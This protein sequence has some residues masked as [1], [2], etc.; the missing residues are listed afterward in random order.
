MWSLALA[1]AG[2]CCHPLQQTLLR[3]AE[4]L[5]V[6]AGAGLMGIVAAHFC[7]QLTLTD[8]DSH[9]LDN[10]RLSVALNT[11]LA[12]RL[13]VEKLE[14]GKHPQAW[15]SKFDVILGVE[16]LFTGM[17]ETLD[18]FTD[19]KVDWWETHESLAQTIAFC[20]KKPSGQAR[21]FATERQNDSEKFV[22][23]ASRLGLHCQ[24]Q[25]VTL[26]APQRQTAER[27]GYEPDSQTNLIYVSW[28]KLPTVDEAPL[29]C[30]MQF[31]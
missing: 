24:V 4:V 3:G 17:S 15:A 21:L 23:H 16:V 18:L 29:E 11:G 28:Q 7:K 9:C 30:H 14:F 26:Q 22:R 12:Q 10:L 2:W 27:L 19:E 25:P 8:F 31:A 5:E 6:G 20:L 13:Q 1:A